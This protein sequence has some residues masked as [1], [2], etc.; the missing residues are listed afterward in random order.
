MDIN[1]DAYFSEGIE[2]F[3]AANVGFHSGDINGIV[4]LSM[5]NCGFD[6]VIENA[7][8]IKFAKNSSKPYLHVVL[9]EHS[10]KSNLMTKLEIFME[11]ITI[12][13]QNRSKKD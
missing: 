1:F 5:F 13:Q 8:M 9:D 10:T 2:I 7:I 6:A 4:Y 12:N 11:L 3:N